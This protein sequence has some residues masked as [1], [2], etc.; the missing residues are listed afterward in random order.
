MCA[1]AAEETRR[2]FRVMTGKERDESTGKKDISMGKIWLKSTDPNKQ[3][4]GCEGKSGPCSSCCFP[5]TGTAGTELYSDGYFKDKVIKYAF[6]GDFPDMYKNRGIENNW[7]DVGT[8]AR[9]NSSGAGAPLA[10]LNVGILAFEN[11]GTRMTFVGTNPDYLRNLQVCELVDQFI[12]GDDFNTPP[13]YGGVNPDEPN[14]IGD[15]AYFEIKFTVNSG[16]YIRVG[17]TMQN[18]TTDY[19]L[20]RNYSDP[21]TIKR[22]HFHY[23]R[24]ASI[25]YAA[26]SGDTKPFQVSGLPGRSY[27]TFDPLNDVSTGWEYRDFAQWD[28]I[29]ASGRGSFEDRTVDPW[30]FYPGACFGL[31]PASAGIGE[32]YPYTYNIDTN[33]F[34]PNPGHTQ[35]T[36]YAVMHTSRKWKSQIETFAHVRNS[37]T[38]C[39]VVGA[40]MQQQEIWDDFWY[41]DVGD[42]LCRDSLPGPVFPDIQPSGIGHTTSLK[43]RVANIVKRKAFTFSNG[44]I[45]PEISQESV[46]SMCATFQGIQGSTIELFDTQNRP[47]P[48]SGRLRSY[49]ML[50]EEEED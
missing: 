23:K 25:S 19:E 20:W 24:R 3:C 11:T 21:T 8:P 22:G 48:I 33:T 38:F 12:P 5:Y 37:T 34:Y 36:H 28:A 13:C 41:H 2:L 43:F 17:S 39:G 40:T 16:E 9:F 31:Q 44:V 27:Y 49:T 10:T 46:K 29:Y 1:K 26:F 50:E 32:N 45:G 4:C 6:T 42:N 15:S 30:V 18:I 7:F 35:I 47:I 14:L